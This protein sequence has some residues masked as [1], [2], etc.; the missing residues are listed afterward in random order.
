[1]YPKREGVGGQ[2]SLSRFLGGHWRFKIFGGGG[3]S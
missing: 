1:M 3:S 2:K